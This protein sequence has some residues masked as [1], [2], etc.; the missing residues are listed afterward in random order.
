MKNKTGK[1]NETRK[2]KNKKNYLKKMYDYVFT[3]PVYLQ[4]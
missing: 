3:P 4:I 2:M 1:L